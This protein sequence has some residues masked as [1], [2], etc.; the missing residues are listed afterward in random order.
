[1]DFCKCTSNNGFRHNDNPADNGGEVRGRPTK[2]SQREANLRALVAKYAATPPAERNRLD[3][4]ERVQ[5]HLSE[6]AFARLVEIENEDPASSQSSQQPSASQY[7]DDE[8]PEVAT[9]PQLPTPPRPKQVRMQNK[10]RVAAASTSGQFCEHAYL[11]SKK[12]YPYFSRNLAS[13]FHF[14]LG[15]YVTIGFFLA[16]GFH[17]ASGYNV[18]AAFHF[19]ELRLPRKQDQSIGQSCGATAEDA[20]LF[21]LRLKHWLFPERTFICFNLVSFPLIWPLL[22]FMYPCKT[23]CPLCPHY[24]HPS[25]IFSHPTSHF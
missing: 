25:S 14:A 24:P 17:F 19:A 7:V 1:M 4:L 15:F 11:W 8:D 20:R 10:G 16:I 21:V 12:N 9:A 2:I 18:G 22:S 5:Y 6:T 13:A 3:Y 23:C